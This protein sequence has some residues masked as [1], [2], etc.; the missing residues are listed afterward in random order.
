MDSARHRAYTGQ[1]NELILANLEHISRR[2]DCTIIVRCPVIPPCNDRA[3]NLHALG[4]FLTEKAIRCSEIN[5]LPYHNLGEGKR[6]Q[7]EPG[8]EGFTS[9]TPSQEEVELLRDILRGYGFVVK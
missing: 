2:T 5:L 1:G 6:E 9:R 4:R 8:T 7:L 3:E